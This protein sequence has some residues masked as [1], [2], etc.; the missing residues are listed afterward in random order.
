MN[1]KPIPFEVDPFYHLV[2]IIHLARKAVIAERTLRD[3][4]DVRKLYP[5]LDQSLAVT[6]INVL[7]DESLTHDAANALSF[8]AR[9]LERA[10]EQDMEGDNSGT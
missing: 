10:H 4:E 7:D 1:T 2:P 3:L 8:V 9:V 5:D 6:G